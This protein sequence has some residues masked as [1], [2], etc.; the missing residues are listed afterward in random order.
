VE[1]LVVVGS[2]LFAFALVVA[3]RLAQGIGGQKAAQ[4]RRMKLSE[5][6]GPFLQA[7][8]QIQSVFGAIAP[9]RYNSIGY[10]QNVIF[11]ITDRAIVVLDASMTGRP[12][13]VRQRYSSNLRLGPLHKSPWGLTG[14]IFTFGDTT[15]RVPWRNFAEVEAAD[16]AVSEMAQ[17]E[18]A[19]SV[20]RETP[21]TSSPDASP[22]A[23]AAAAADTAVSD[24]VQPQDVSASPKPRK[25]AIFIRA[26]YLILGVVFFLTLIRVAVQYPLLRWIAIPILLLYVWRIVHYLGRLMHRAWVGHKGIHAPIWLVGG[27]LVGGIAAAV[28]PGDAGGYVAWLVWAVSLIVA[29]VLFIGW[30]QDAVGRRGAVSARRS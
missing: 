13:Q 29:L 2:L 17:H 1:F 25:A 27:F 6:V 5:Q 21:R 15:Y 12:T 30:I 23:A 4:R 14:G 22:D 18:P 10:E 16:A 26:W 28:I 8:E 9:A 19:D 3:L 7:G 11:A 20:G 24:A